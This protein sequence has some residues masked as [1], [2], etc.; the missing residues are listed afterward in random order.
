MTLKE[1]IINEREDFFVR[2]REKRPDLFEKLKTSK[3][4]QDFESVVCDFIDW[5]QK[6]G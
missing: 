3:T 4:Y 5:E 6:N 1:F 2:M